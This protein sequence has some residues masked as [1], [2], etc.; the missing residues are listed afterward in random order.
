MFWFV[1]ASI[2]FLPWPSI[3]FT[4]FSNASPR[5]KYVNLACSITLFWPGGNIYSPEKYLYLSI[6]PDHR[7]EFFVISML[8]SYCSFSSLILSSI[9]MISFHIL[10]KRFL[11]KHKGLSDA[12]VASAKRFIKIQKVFIVNIW[13]M[14]KLSFL[15][16][17][18][19]KIVCRI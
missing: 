14:I 7:A 16:C 2:C 12:R 10:S 9:V 11:L 19:N 15:W 17:F 1:I 4:C 6:F 5:G 8:I 13:W 3:V 18:G